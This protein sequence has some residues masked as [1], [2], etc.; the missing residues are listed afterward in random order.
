MP[1]DVHLSL[2]RFRPYLNKNKATEHF[3]QLIRSLGRSFCPLVEIL[4]KWLILL[5]VW[6][7]NS[8]CLRSCLYSSVA[9]CPAPIPPLWIKPISP[10]SCAIY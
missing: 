9:R 2:R 7:L 1:D 4:R 3:N 5:M 8:L 6:F 10:I